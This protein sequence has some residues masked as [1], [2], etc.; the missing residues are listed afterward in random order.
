MLDAQGLQGPAVRLDTGWF[1][2]KHVDEMVCFVPTG[3]V[4]R[5]HRVLVPST[6]AMVELLEEWAEQGL[7]DAPLL[8]PFEEEATV[9]SLLADGELM[10][11]NRA[12]ESERIAPNVEIL[13]EAFSLEEADFIRI[14]ALV[15]ERGTSIFPNMVNSV[16][17]NG[18]FLVSDPHGPEVDGE[19]LLQQHV[20][21]LL[22]DL[23]LTIHFVDDRRYHMGSGNTH[24]A[25]NVLR[26]GFDEPWWEHTGR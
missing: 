9:A 8:Q 1:L 18:H 13:K 17:L 7:G 26:E 5:P 23:P 14:P 21:S 2:I 15:S 24:C 22:E 4:D 25:T 12:L 11:H 20:R 6:A 10:E 3:D 16:V 19:D